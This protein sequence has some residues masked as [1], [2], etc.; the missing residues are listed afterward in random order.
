MVEK[1]RSAVPSTARSRGPIPVA[2]LGMSLSLFLL[3]SYLISLLFLWIAPGVLANDPVIAHFLLGQDPLG[4]QGFLL[5]VVRSF[6]CGWFI[7]LIFAPLYNFIA[8]R[9]R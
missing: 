4:W 6:A 1:T 5:G 2:V 7:A 8:V 9:W 3:I